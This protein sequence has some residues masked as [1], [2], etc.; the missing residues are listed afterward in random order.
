VAAASFSHVSIQ[1]TSWLTGTAVG[2]S[3]GSVSTSGVTIQVSGRGADIWGTADAF[4][5]AATPWSSDVV[6]TARVGRLSNTDVWAKAAVM[7]RESLGRQLEAL[8]GGR[9]A[10]ERSVVVIPL[11]DRRIE[12][13]GHEVD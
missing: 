8:D 3:S 9:D 5:F 13:A 12:R 2:S 7:V 6:I 11:D 1:P 4:F 10:R